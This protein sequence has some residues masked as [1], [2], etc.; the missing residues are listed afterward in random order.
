MGITNE[1]VELAQRNIIHMAKTAQKVPS[2]K[3]LLSRLAKNKTGYQFK[4]SQILMYVATHLM[5]QLDWVNDE[6]RK[7]LQ[8]IAFFHDITLENSEQAMIYSNESLRKADFTDEEKESV[9]RH[10][11]VAASLASQYP[12]APVGVEQII[13]Q[14]HGMANGLGFSEHYSQ[15]ISPMAI[16]FILSE[17]FVDSILTGGENF[18]VFAQ[19]KKMREKYTTQRFKKIID[20]LETLVL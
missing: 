3:E 17:D 16:V 11:Q 9:K 12:N 10:A 7:K 4:H 15:N 18:S 14:H 2:L 5:N 8:F 20:S 6:Q 1:T 13:K 19:I